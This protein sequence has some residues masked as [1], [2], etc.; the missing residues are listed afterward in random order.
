MDGEKGRQAALLDERDSQRGPDT[1]GFE[2]G[3]LAALPKA[4]TVVD[5]QQF[6]RLEPRPHVRAEPR[7]RVIADEAR[8]ARRVPLAAHGEMVAVR[9]DGRIG[10]DIGTEMRA[11]E[12]AGR[13]EDVER[14]TEPA[15]RARQ[16]VEEAQA[17]AGL[18]ALALGLGEFDHPARALG[19]LLHEAHVLG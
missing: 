6:A 3:G 10:A 13:I 15:D 16:L 7:Q 1:E 11:E 2:G 9:V 5:G 19:D 8:R 18:A 14:R 4:G 12:A 17:L